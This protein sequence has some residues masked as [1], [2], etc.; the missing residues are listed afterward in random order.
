MARMSEEVM[1]A[2]ADVKPGIIATTSRSGKPNVSAKGSFRVI[3][4]EHVAFAEIR[5]PNTLANLK[6][7]PEVAILCLDPATRHG[8]RI[9]GRAEILDS[10]PLFDQ[11]SQE[12]AARKMTVRHA[13]RIAVDASSVF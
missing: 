10:G 1:K 9:S 5:S 3:D 4:D 8:C 12:F 6:E 7:N 2:V 13:I 11:L